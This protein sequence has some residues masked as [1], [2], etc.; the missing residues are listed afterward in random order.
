MTAP[1]QGVETDHVEF[2]AGKVRYYRAGHSGPAVVLLHGGGIDNAMLSWRHTIATLSVDHRVYLPDL[3]RYGDSR[4]WHGRAGQRTLEELLRWLLDEWG[5]QRATLVGL[6][7]GGS[8]ATGFA[9]RHPHRVNGLVLVG[10][11]GLQHRIPHQT[12]TYLL[13]RSR[14]AGPMIARSMRWSNGL[15]RRYLRG[16][17]HDRTQVHDLEALTRELRAELRGLQSVFSDW[18]YDAV[19]RRTMKVNHLPQ[20]HRIQCPMMVIHGAA[21]A[22][23]PVSVA[24]EAAGAVRGSKLRVI[25]EAG[26]WC[27]REKPNEFNAAIREFLNHSF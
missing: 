18:Q 20:L 17:L 15:C 26:H 7:T 9:L 11:G 24:H 21:D 2:P 25:P 4:E 22:Q 19:E 10:A 3:P 14:V 23:V 1:P 8:A 12:L 5:V 16:V 6:S 13:V 27:Q